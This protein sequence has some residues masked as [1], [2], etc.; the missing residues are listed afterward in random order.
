[1]TIRAPRVAAPLQTFGAI[2]QVLGQVGQAVAAVEQANVRRSAQWQATQAPQW[3]TL[4]QEADATAPKVKPTDY[5]S[6]QE[7]M[8]AIEARQGGVFDTVRSHITQGIDPQDG[9]RIAATDD[10]LATLKGA[11]LEAAMK[12][13][14]QEWAVHY[15]A[16]QET[17][18][19]TM[20]VGI[21]RGELSYEDALAQTDAQRTA[22]ETDGYLNQDQINATDRRSRDELTRLYLD[23][24]LVEGDVVE[25]ERVLGTT[26]DL[27]PDRY[28]FYQVRLASRRAELTQVNI[29]ATT[30][31]MQAELEAIGAGFD[32]DPKRA[33]AEWQALTPEQQASPQVAALR[34]RL[35]AGRE[36]QGDIGQIMRSS[37]AQSHAEVQAAV[38]S[39][40]DDPTQMHR[41][42]ALAKAHE[43][44][45]KALKED[46]IAFARQLGVVTDEPLDWTNDE[47]VAKARAL[48][49]RVSDVYGIPTP[50]MTKAE[51]KHAREWIKTDPDVAGHIMLRL[52]S[53]YGDDEDGLD[54]SLA[55]LAG[56][57]V[58]LQATMKNLAY[59]PQYR[60]EAL[61]GLKIKEDKQASALYGAGY[62]S[63]VKASETYK[64][65][66]AA[67]GGDVAAKL[68]QQVELIYLGRM[69]E[70]GQA[71]GGE[72]DPELLEEAIADVTNGGPM[73]WADGVILPPWQGATE[74]NVRDALLGFLYKRTDNALGA[75]WGGLDDLE[76][77]IY[78]EELALVSVG[79]GQYHIV[80]WD[81]LPVRDPDA[82]D[83]RT[84]LV[85]SLTEDL[86]AF[87]RED[88]ARRAVAAYEN[89]SIWEK[90]TDQVVPLY[91]DKDTQRAL[92]GQ[93]E[94]A[95]QAAAKAA[96]AEA[97]AQDRVKDARAAKTG[98]S[99]A[100]SGGIR[101]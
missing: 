78:D 15:K 81:G 56:K 12:N 13:G 84:P 53:L 16:S 42:Q 11:N 73:E 85:V 28:A 31:T 62:D 34:E 38:A 58:G 72:A 30:E 88:S 74:E 82:D 2:Q 33:E 91:F 40:R 22:M 27:E 66:H 96:E 55:Q 43:Q 86:A 19:R 87:G 61:A 49:Q 94:Q 97:L 100:G 17:F 35:T 57:D 54:A 7:Y 46:P 68:G 18:T 45:T 95:N 20:G 79:D 69:A 50:L 23:N 93:A 9:W 48:A 21:A 29:T 71:Y 32:V 89:R 63:A 52:T 83:I 80:G 65:L 3:M 24:R 101:G 36:L 6:E 51:A 70:R 44:K 14:Q 77:Q 25:A 37:P 1:M 60:D 67:V 75:H 41:A 47:S 4:A 90:I 76:D 98:R 39:V 10:G 26:T 99:I 92:A 8:T 64:A 59:L 5:G